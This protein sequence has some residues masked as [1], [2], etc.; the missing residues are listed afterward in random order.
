MPQSK[1]RRPDTPYEVTVGGLIVKCKPMTRGELLELATES[2]TVQDDHKALD[3]FMSKISSYVISIE[4]YDDAQKVLEYQSAELMR[5]LF[6]AILGGAELTEGETKNSP[7]LSD[8]QPTNP[9]KAKA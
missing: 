3:A 1:W 2:Q 7:S 6:E 8:T 4:S 5:E 9:N